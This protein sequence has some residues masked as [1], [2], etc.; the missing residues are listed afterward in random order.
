MNAR[1]KTKLRDVEKNKKIKINKKCSKCKKSICCNSI[2]QKVETP[3]TKLDFDHLLW[4]VSHENVN[5]FKD[6]DGWFLHVYTRC[7][8]LLEGGVCNIYDTRPLVCREY[9]NDFCER[10]ESIE[11]ASEFFF[12][13]YKQLEKYCRKRFKKWDKRFK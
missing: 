8:H 11:E 3:K 2:N 6:A 7:D 10:D 13:T 1:N 5:V 9:D 12:T 4:Q